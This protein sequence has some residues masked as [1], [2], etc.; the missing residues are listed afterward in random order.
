M[1]PSLLAR[2]IQHGLKQFLVTGF[3]TS[4]TFLHGLM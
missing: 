3:E 1:L 4:D 2:D